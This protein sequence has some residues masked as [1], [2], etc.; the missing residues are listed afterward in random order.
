M[1]N[2]VIGKYRGFDIE[3]DFEAEL[4][5]CSMSSA[6]L[7]LIEHPIID[8]VKSEIDMHIK[9]IENGETKTVRTGIDNSSAYVSCESSSAMLDS[10]RD[11][12]NAIKNIETKQNNGLIGK[13][14]K[15]KF[16][17]WNSECNR[18]DIIISGI[19]LD[20]C[21]DNGCTSYLIKLDDDLTTS[22]LGERIKFC[23]NKHEYIRHYFIVS[24]FDK[25]KGDIIPVPYTNIIK[26]LN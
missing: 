26:V 5:V 17:N 7:I 8:D 12:L 23:E 13:A 14:V 15:A 1:A 16:E 6:P 3:Y 25:K 9:S 4:F 22:K 19:V 18:C 11:R 10:I 21:I 2:T 24:N 20:K